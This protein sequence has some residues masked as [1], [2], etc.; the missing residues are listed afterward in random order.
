M[1]LRWSRMQTGIGEKSDV[2]EKMEEIEKQ[3]F[4]ERKNAASVLKAPVAV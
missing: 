2:Y 4:P 3:V 1:V